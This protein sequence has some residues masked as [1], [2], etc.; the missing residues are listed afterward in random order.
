MFEQSNGFIS[1]IR[2]LNAVARTQM[3]LNAQVA[4]ILQLSRKTPKNLRKFIFVDPKLKLQ[5]RAEELKI[6]EG[7]VFT[8]LH[9]SLLVRKQCSRVVAGFAHSRSKTTRLRFRALF[10]TVSTQQKGVFA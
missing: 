8:I 9:K 2:T 1:V 3:M 7:S 5:E 4:Q 10:A 6:S